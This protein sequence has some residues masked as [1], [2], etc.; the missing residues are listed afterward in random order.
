[1]AEWLPTYIAATGGKY[2]Q[3][4]EWYKSDRSTYVSVSYHDAANVEHWVSIF[5][6]IPSSADWKQFSS[7]FFLPADAKDI[8]F[9]HA[10]NGVGF[11]QLD[12][13]SVTEADAPPGFDQ[14]MVSLTFD[15]GS[16]GFY[17]NARPLLRQNGFLST[18]YMPSWGLTRTP[19]DTFMMTDAE[20]KQLA[21]DGNEIGGHSVTH[22]SLALC[23]GGNGD[24]IASTTKDPN[25]PARMLGAYPD[26]C[27]MYRLLRAIPVSSRPTW[28]G[29]LNTNKSDLLRIVP[30]ATIDDF[31][32]PFGE[33]NDTVIQ[34][35]QAAG[36][37]M[38]RG[39]DGGYNAR[40]FQPYAIRVQNM[41]STT[42]QAEFESW[43]NFARDNK[44]W[45]VIV[46]HEVLTPD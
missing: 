17:D 35:V 23:S 28:T 46:Y 19:R 22:P 11:L 34:R 30:G 33:Y 39:V 6:A 15:D 32:Y 41:T 24:C 42:T 37:K 10:L 29:E 12:D 5:A 18:Q 43:V 3:Y 16:Q 31:A 21:A 38:A 36:Y 45:L 25:N 14:G 8:Q 26:P 27:R 20:I 1:M 40:D 4:S 13:F 2:Y 44:V 7:G 9:F